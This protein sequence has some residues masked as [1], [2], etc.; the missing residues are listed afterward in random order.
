MAAALAIKV[1]ALLFGMELGQ[2]GSFYARN[3]SFFVLPLLAGY[4][5]WKRRLDTGTV[6][7]MAVAFIAAGVLANVYPFTPQGSTEVLTVLHLPIALWLIVGIAYA[8]G[9]WDQVSGRMDF[10]RFS[11]ELFI[12]YVLIALGGGVLTGFMAMIYQ[13]IGGSTSN[14]SSGIGRCRAAPWGPS[15]S[16]PGWW[17][18]SRA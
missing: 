15:W 14:P 9:R 17:K 18:P 2:E 3:I 1:P 5:V 4:F 8:G 7:W 16:P 11:G 12:Y 6:R 13:T 10:I